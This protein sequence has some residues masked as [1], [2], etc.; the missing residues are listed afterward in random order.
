MSCALCVCVYSVCRA[1]VCVYCV[2]ARATC[3]V[4]YL[5]SLRCVLRSVE[6]PK[7]QAEDS[8]G[9]ENSD[10]EDEGMCHYS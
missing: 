5:R 8:N 7:A 3:L 2:V 6:K 9:E 10:A 4:A 1:R